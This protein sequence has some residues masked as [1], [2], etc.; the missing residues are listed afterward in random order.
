MR[1]ELRMAAKGVLTVA[2]EVF[3]QLFQN[4]A[5]PCSRGFPSTLPRPT[6]VTSAAAAVQRGSRPVDQQWFQSH[7]KLR[8]PQVLWRLWVLLGG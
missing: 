4:E 8:T 1:E 6:V 7:I 3:M 5:V 2:T